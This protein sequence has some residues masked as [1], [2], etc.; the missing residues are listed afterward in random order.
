MPRIFDPQS[1]RGAARILQDFRAFRHHRLTNVQFRHLAAQVAESAL[2]VLHDFVIAFQPPPE[3]IRDSLASQVVL[4]RAEPARRNDQLDASERLAK[5]F[6]QQ[7]FVVADDRLAHHFNADAVELFGEIQRIR[8]KSV[9]REQ[10]RTDRD[11]FCFHR[12]IIRIAAVR[13]RPSPK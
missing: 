7:R 10:F 6:A 9:R 3:Q 4:R 11:D 2:N 1:R 13:G 12:L 8:I 5:H